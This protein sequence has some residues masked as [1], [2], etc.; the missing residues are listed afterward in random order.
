MFN[1][2]LL[3]W[4]HFAFWL[5]TQRSCKWLCWCSSYVFN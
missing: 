2:P 3:A 4:E 1:M 5:V